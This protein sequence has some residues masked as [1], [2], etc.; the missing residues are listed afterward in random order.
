MFELA[1]DVI[2]AL[3]V[4]TAVTDDWL[5]VELHELVKT[6]DKRNC[7]AERLSERREFVSVDQMQRAPTQ[8]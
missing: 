4:C 3:C 7:V 5:T 1:D 6:P 2:D 8:S